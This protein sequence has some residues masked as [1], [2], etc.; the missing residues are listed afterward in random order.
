MSRG[1]KI[2][3]GFDLIDDGFPT[4]RIAEREWPEGMDGHSNQA[5]AV[6]WKRMLDTGSVGATARFGTQA[7]M[8]P[9]PYRLRPQRLIDVK[10]NDRKPEMVTITSVLN[11]AKGYE[12]RPDWLAR[13]H[14]GTEN[15][16]CMAEMD[17]ALGTMATVLCST[18]QVDVLCTSPD[19]ASPENA[20][21]GV[22]VSYGQRAGHKSPQRTLYVEDVAIGTFSDPQRVPFFARDVTLY[23]R[24]LAPNTYWL[25]FLGFDAAT[26]I[27]TVP[28]NS[29]P[30]AGDNW[31][32]G[33]VP[34]PNDAR[35][36]RVF[37]LAGPAV[38]GFYTA[39]FGLAL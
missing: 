15:F 37:N 35:F 31:F 11:D 4:G 5:P 16:Q 36:F 19:G 33:P 29:D 18:L 26:P 6:L 38:P 1:R 10:G 30:A 13:L 32:D 14:W 7:G 39:V 23:S 3:Q 28:Y 21:V 9:I 25:Q 8:L 20:A 24:L 22:Q 12:T 2:R 17:L 34:V 27:A